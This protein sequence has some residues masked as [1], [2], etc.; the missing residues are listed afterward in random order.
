MRVWD[1]W[2]V[3]QKTV[4]K[5]TLPK[6]G[7]VSV[8]MAR[9]SNDGHLI[10]AGLNNG[11]LQS[12]DVRGTPPDACLHST[13]HEQRG[14]LNITEGIGRSFREPFP[15]PDVLTCSALLTW[16]P[17]CKCREVWLLGSYWAGDAAQAADDGQAGLAL[18]LRRWPGA[19]I[20]LPP[21]APSA[22]HRSSTFARLLIVGLP[23][24]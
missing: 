7:R 8:S 3:V 11:T 5:P 23:Q 21:P 15:C 17:R 13:T 20:W 24:S 9:Y 12:W 6:P 18:R 2:N 4:V 14:V 16:V 10:V 19:L 1:T 22:W